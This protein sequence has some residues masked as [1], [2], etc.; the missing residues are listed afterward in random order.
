MIPDR[1][2]EWQ[3]QRRVWS[4]I[5]NTAQAEIRELDEKIVAFGEGERGTDRDIVR[6]RAG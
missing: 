6:D 3:A 4:K 1:I 2:L 5:L